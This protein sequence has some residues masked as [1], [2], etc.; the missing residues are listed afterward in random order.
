[1]IVRRLLLGLTFALCLSV[2]VVC[3]QKP[4]L[5]VQTGHS[6][7]ID[8]LAFS[9]DGNLLISYSEDKT[10]KI[11]DVQSRMELRT[12]ADGGTPVTGDAS[13]KECLH[14]N[15]END[16][17]C[18]ATA[19]KAELLAYLES[20][21]P[22][23]AKGGELRAE[24]SWNGGEVSTYNSK[25]GERR[26][27]SG[28]FGVSTVALSSDGRLL[29]CGL[30]S[31]VIK[32]WDLVRGGDP[33]M[34]MGHTDSVIA[35]AVSRDGQL[36][37]TGS[38]AYQGVEETDSIKVWDIAAGSLVRT[39]TDNF[40]D[41][42]NLAFSSDNRS[43]ASG[44]RDSIKVWNLETG[45][46]RHTLAQESGVNDALVFSQTS[47]ALFNVVDSERSGGVRTW[48]SESGKSRQYLSLRGFGVIAI[49]TDAKLLVAVAN[50][51]K[52]SRPRIKI[53]D[54]AQATSVV[55]LAPGNTFKK[56]DKVT[57][58][59]FSPNHERVA[60]VFSSGMIGLWDT[61]TGRMLHRFK[62]EAPV[63]ISHNGRFLAAPLGNDIA[64][65]DAVS[66]SLYR[67][68]K[69]HT[70]MVASLSFYGSDLL[71]SGSLDTTT[72]VW[73]VGA[74][75]ELASLIA[76]D[77]SDWLVVTPDGLFDGTA[78]AMRQV[79]WRVGTSLEIVPLDTFFNDFFHPGLLVEIFR[80]GRP[81]A[82][83]DIAMVLQ[84][85]SLRTML[86]QRLARQEQRDGKTVVCFKDEPTTLNISLLSNGQ[87]VSVSGFDFVPTDSACRYRKALP[88][89]TTQVQ[90]VN[91]L[92]EQRR[93][94]ETS[95]A[96]MP[97][98]E[99]KHSTLHVLTVAVKDYPAAS[100]VRPLPFAVSGAKA[101]EDFFIAQRANPAKPFADVR[102]S[103]LYDGEA[104]RAAIRERLT[105]LANEVNPEDVVF[106]FISGHGLV[107]AG[108]EM[109]YFVPVD[110]RTGGLEEYRETGI[111]TAMLAEALRNLPARRVVL[112]IDACQSGGAVESLAKIGEVKAK[113]ELRTAGGKNAAARPPI[114][115][116]IIASAAPLQYAQ[117]IPSLGNG[118][119]VTALLEALQTQEPEGDGKVW[120]SELAARIRQRTPEISRNASG[121][122]VPLIQTPL[123]ETMGADF[124]LAARGPS[125]PAGTQ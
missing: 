10:V 101:V 34:L 93:G 40:S 104:T 67:T 68:L 38:G 118:A 115:V 24:G 83:V 88:E 91:A 21:Q 14:V 72:K 78:D 90:L 81:Q 92:D 61:E 106:L 22:D 3:A 26:S 33:H 66:G 75:K 100:G 12:L 111:N 7:I 2:G 18:W 46:P 30:S 60:V 56:D 94:T 120:A 11:W 15:D 28:G 13:R 79:S 8:R 69:G 27:F 80:G 43:L 105:A 17:S 19:T 82:S 65:Y 9:P 49:S 124:P 37:A 63:A 53:T 35:L 116:D 95:P 5:V 102:V 87:P 99:T 117:Q 51:R 103:H 97:K 96:D 39:L 76:I 70:N 77:K 64:V 89:G 108:Q 42:Y 74:G 84:L 125:T 58:A 113:S 20:V 59:A 31:G 6:N 32:V 23:V 29:A 36:I 55:F 119:L 73:D 50:D 109:F 16:L 112:V 54:V 114:G 57:F 86:K 25:T 1:M 4:E 45:K 107:P 98:S 48:N 41:V 121:G 52:G 71:L 122:S 123:I 85:P 62:G 110:G 44:S 47:T